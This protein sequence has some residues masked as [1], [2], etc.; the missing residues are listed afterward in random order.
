MRSAGNGTV[1]FEG[2]YG[3]KGLYLS[4]DNHGVGLS[5]NND[6]GEKWVA[7]KMSNGDYYFISKKYSGK[8]LSHAFA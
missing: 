2:M 5:A 7:K 8:V 3:E 4:S 1:V 6:N